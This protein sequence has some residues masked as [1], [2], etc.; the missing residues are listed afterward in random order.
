MD[1]T[2]AKSLLI[3]EAT[4]FMSELR[5]RGHFNTAITSE[6][7]EKMPLDDLRAIHRSLRDTLRTLGGSKP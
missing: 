4:T 1:D 3:M 5:E 7:M 6:A 2:M